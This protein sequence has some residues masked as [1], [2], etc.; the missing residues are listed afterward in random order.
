MKLVIESW[1]KFLAEAEQ[2]SDVSENPINVDLLD[3]TNPRHIETL[4]KIFNGSVD[5]NRLRG[6]TE[7]LQKKAKLAHKWKTEYAARDRGHKGAG[8][9]KKYWNPHTE[10]W[11]KDTSTGTASNQTG[12]SR[13]ALHQ[14]EMGKIDQELYNIGKERGVGTHAFRNAINTLANFG[15]MFADPSGQFAGF[16]DVEGGGKR[17]VSS[18]EY[19]NRAKEDYKKNPGIFNGAM[20][21]LSALAFVPLIGVVGKGGRAAGKSI[22]SSMK[23]KK[24]SKEAIENA[25]TV[26]Q[27]L[28]NLPPG[29][30]TAQIQKVAD[31]LDQEIYKLESLISTRTTSFLN[32]FQRQINKKI[33]GKFR[34]GKIAIIDKYA[35]DGRTIQ[36][37]NPIVFKTQGKFDPNTGKA[38]V[39]RV[40]VRVYSDASGNAKP[41]NPTSDG[42]YR[43]SENTI[44]INI[45]IHPADLVYNKAKGTRTLENQAISSGIMQKIHR[46]MNQT[47]F[48]EFVHGNQ[49]ARSIMG[50]D[51]KTWNMTDRNMRYQSGAAVGDGSKKYNQYRNQAIEI[52]PMGRMAQVRPAQLRK[53]PTAGDSLDYLARN[54]GPGATFEFDTFER[55]LKHISD[56]RGSRGS[57]SLDD[58]A[59]TI[60][61]NLG[62]HIETGTPFPWNPNLRHGKEGP[63]QGVYRSKSSFETMRK[64]IEALKKSAPCAAITAANAVLLFHMGLYAKPNPKKK[65]SYNVKDRKVIDTLMAAA[66]GDAK[67]RKTPVPIDPK[68]CSYKSLREWEEMEDLKLLIEEEVNNY[69]KER[70]LL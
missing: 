41:G 52:E 14:P 23:A 64:E 24:A 45:D 49:K 33:M 46:T 30:Q 40:E 17:A 47:G 44:F 1:R 10:K 54:S 9:N 43:G 27:E 69:L 12:K 62:K 16:E 3:P 53:N 63:K 19:Y 2:S 61:Q 59:P 21:A 58:I 50:K 60:A 28:Y 65:Y 35:P 66:K 55:F 37:P 70:S 20:V 67:A 15:L 7:S 4:L 31:D 38:A 25:K 68:G 29:Q 13:K 8:K 36:H 6:D 48:H 5:A 57:T 32:N 26:R 42:L 56:V 11:Q 22:K 18:I 34:T 39:E 51:L